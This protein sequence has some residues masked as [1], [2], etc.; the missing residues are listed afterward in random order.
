MAEAAALAHDLGHP[1]FGH[2]GEKEL[3]SLTE[4]HGCPDGFEGN[5][6]SFRI[7][8]RLAAHR[9][10]Y[11]G[12]NLTR[13]TLRATLKYPWLRSKKGTS[14]KHAKFGAYDS[15]RDALRFACGGAT[16]SDQLSPE[17]E[18]MDYADDLAYSVHDFD[19]FFRAGIIPLERIIASD[20]EFRQ[21][22]AKW[23]SDGRVTKSEVEEHGS[24]LLGFLRL[25]RPSTPYQGAWDHRVEMRARTA[26]LIALGVNSAHVRRK[27]NRRN[28][29][30]VAPPRVE[31]AFRFLRQLVWHYVIDHPQLATQ[32]HGHR[33]I[34]RDLFHIY[35]EALKAG[36]RYLI[37]AQF[38]HV[39]PTDDRGC[40]RC[41]ADIV[42]SLTDQQALALHRRLSGTYVGSVNEILA[43]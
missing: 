8:T 39:E 16:S 2:V 17:A 1:P 28:R 14:R 15:D 9:V 26:S 20:A 22:L 33:R 6:Q 25:L 30:L 11:A 41:A 38:R 24:T 23:L 18:I 34:I 13:A 7:I 19:D 4:A 27:P 40:S 21:I 35:R 3:C 12:L 31:L 5:A 29:R 32:Q 43:G 42:A 37:P 36:D 10:G